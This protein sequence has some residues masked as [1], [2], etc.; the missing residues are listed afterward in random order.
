[1]ITVQDIENIEIFSGLSK[2][3]LERLAQKAG[4]IQLCRGD[5]LSR[6]GDSAYFNIVLQGQLSLHKDYLGRRQEILVFGKFMVGDFIGEIPILLAGGKTMASVR[7]DADCRLAQFEPQE[8]HR[9]LHDSKNCHDMVMSTM[10]NRM[11]RIREFY[12]ATASTRAVIIGTKHDQECRHI[13]HFLNMN[14]ISYEWIDR[15]D[16]LACVAAGMPEKANHAM[17]KIDQG[18]WFP[19]APTVRSVANALGLNTCPVKKQYDVLIVGGGPA[20]LAAAVYGASEGLNVLMVEKNAAGGQAGTSARIENYLGFPDGISGEEMSERALR[21]AERFGAE[22]CLTRT[23]TNIAPLKGGGFVCKLDGDTVF[24]V[25]SIILATGVNWRCLEA[26]GIK[27]LQGRG[28]LYGASKPEASTVIGKDIFIVG[29][30]NSAGQAAAFFSNYA[31]TVTILVRNEGLKRTMSQYLID[32]IAQKSN[33]KIETFTRLLAVEGE[34]R[35]EHIVTVKNSGQ[36]R[37]ATNRRKAD[38]LFILI[39]A[40][41]NTSWLPPGLQRDQDGFICTGMDIP[42]LSAW[43]KRPPFPL[44]TSIPGIFCAGDVR[45]SSI[46]R[47][48]SGVGEGSMA[49]TFV[50]QFLALQQ[51]I[52]KNAKKTANTGALK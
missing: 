16:E 39:G 14:R 38:A 24:N 45:H 2:E 6:E 42:D 17:V 11:A 13:R 41:A 46:K 25:K 34:E 40:S 5:W 15:D 22:I 12:T 20:G 29:G 8:L 3:D 48:A 50:H 36:N 47:V 18:N 4:D 37:R 26:E 30:G 35:L 23:V 1:M 10:A 44:E 27:K 49:I 9:L 52:G 7:A 28:V 31:R 33:I 19:H 51:R 21:Q 32:K 43:K